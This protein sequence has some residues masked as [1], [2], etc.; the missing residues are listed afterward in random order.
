MTENEICT[1][2]IGTAIDVHTALGPGLL[3]STYQHC[4][5]YELKNLGFVIEEEK[6]MPLVFKEVIL[7]CGYRIDLLVENSLDVEIKSV[8]E[9]KDIHLAQILTYLRMGNYKLG[10]LLNFNV[11]SMKDGIKRVVNRL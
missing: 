3:E 4:L 1:K 8:S 2:V 9:F 5:G 7:E 6:S 11:V 10:L